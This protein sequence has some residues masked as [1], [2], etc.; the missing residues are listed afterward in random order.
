MKH[1][2]LFFSKDKSKKIKC[3]LL[4][5]LFGALRVKHS[6]NRKKTSSVTGQIASSDVMRNS[7]N[8]VLMSENAVCDAQPSDA[9]FIDIVLQQI[10]STTYSNLA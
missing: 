4:Q 8:S 10:N 1:Q 2:A 5:F 6:E 9:I 7:A 3:H